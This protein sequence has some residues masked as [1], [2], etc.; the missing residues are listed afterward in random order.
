MLDKHKDQNNLKILSAGLSQMQQ[1]KQLAISLPNDFDTN[2]TVGL[3]ATIGRRC[4]QLK[5]FYISTNILMANTVDMF[6]A[7][8][9]HMSPQLRRLSVNCYPNYDKKLV[10]TSGSLQRL[11]RLTH[12]AFRVHKWRIIGD[13]FSVTFI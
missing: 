1:L 10:L 12:L 13:Q 5:Q 11:Y 7:I 6:A 8:N 9:E 3:L 2:Q 4:R